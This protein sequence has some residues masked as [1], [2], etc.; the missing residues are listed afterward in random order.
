MFSIFIVLIL[1]PIILTIK[2]RKFDW[3]TLLPLI[4]FIALSQ[5]TIVFAKI[6]YSKYENFFLQFANMFYELFNLIINP[7]APTNTTFG[8]GRAKLW[9]DS[10]KEILSNPIWGTGN[11]KSLP[12]SE[13]LQLAE[14]WG[15]PCLTLY[16]SGIIIIL[17][18]CFKH[19]RKLSNISLI[20]LFATIS[21]LI[22]ACF[23]NIM[24]HIVPYFIIVLAILTRWSNVDIKKAKLQQQIQTEGIE[25]TDN[26]VL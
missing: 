7:T 25:I 26:N 8:T 9:Y 4:G 13:Y 23:G 14:T 17:L 11:T 2:N 1:M 19:L 21:Y 16:L 18:K 3:Q 22:S 20:L 24:P 10:L 15:L 6:Y 5:I 12:H